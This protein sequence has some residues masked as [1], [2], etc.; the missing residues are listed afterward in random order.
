MLSN[1]Q[2]KNKAKIVILVS[3]CVT[4][5]HSSFSMYRNFENSL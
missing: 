3:E 2:S 4:N 1:T 5:S